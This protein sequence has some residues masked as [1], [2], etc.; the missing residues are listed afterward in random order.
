MTRIAKNLLVSA[1]VLLAGLAAIGVLMLASVHQ[2]QAHEANKRPAGTTLEVSI[3]DAGKVLVRGAEVTAVSENSISARTE[4]GASALNW[5]VETDGDTSFLGRDGSG[6]DENDIAI[7]DTVSFSGSLDTNG[8]TFTVDADAV[9]N[10]SHGTNDTDRAERNEAR[11][12]AKTGL[13]AKWGDWMRG[14]PLLN[15]FNKHD[16]R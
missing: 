2:A 6:L 8:S 16:N 12:E 13:R 7:G 10:W 4:W 9:K 15:W 11:V 14:A 5:T 1:A 3:T